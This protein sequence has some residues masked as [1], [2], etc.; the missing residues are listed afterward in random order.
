MLALV[1]FVLCFTLTQTARYLE[2]RIARR[3]GGDLRE[4]GVQLNQIN[5]LATEPTP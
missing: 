1:Y 2:R 4:P 3:R 5:P